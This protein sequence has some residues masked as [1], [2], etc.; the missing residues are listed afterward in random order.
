MVY[1]GGIRFVFVWTSYKLILEITFEHD[2][3][4]LKQVYFET[5]VNISENLH[6]ITEVAACY[7]ITTSDTY[8]RKIVKKIISTKIKL[9]WKVRK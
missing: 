7:S 6:L 9:K 5:R 3:N 1:L 2:E 4:G 8:L